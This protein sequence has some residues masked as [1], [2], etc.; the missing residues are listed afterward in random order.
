MGEKNH[1]KMYFSAGFCLNF[2]L[3]FHYFSS[4]L[5]VFSFVVFQIEGEIY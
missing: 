5:A 4:V 2:L 1:R 3:K